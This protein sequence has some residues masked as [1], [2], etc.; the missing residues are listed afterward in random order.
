MLQ[1]EKPK[2]QD[3]LCQTYARNVIGGCGHKLRKVVH[4]LNVCIHEN[5]S[6]YECKTFVYLHVCVSVCM[7]EKS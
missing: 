2:N 6:I 4:P 3:D 1:E 5:I 7:Y